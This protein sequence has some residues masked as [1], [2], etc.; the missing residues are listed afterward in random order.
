[1]AEKLFA[2]QICQ[3]I[4]MTA[5]LLPSKITSVRHQ[6]LT[7]AYYQPWTHRLSTTPKYKLQMLCIA[8]WGVCRVDQTRPQPAT[9]LRC[10]I[11]SYCQSITYTM[12]MFI[13]LIACRDWEAKI[14]RPKS[15][16]YFSHALKPRAS[17]TKILTLPAKQMY[18]PTKGHSGIDCTSVPYSF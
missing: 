5:L 10:P 12:N 7:N 13:A 15:M 1:M 2:M 17:Y 9:W 16:V 14:W 6:L 3:W 18:H 8:F 11:L 4:R